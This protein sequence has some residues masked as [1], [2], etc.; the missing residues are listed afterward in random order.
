MGRNRSLRRLRAFSRWEKKAGGGKR[1]VMR[2][3]LRKALEEG[4]DSWAAEHMDM[5]AGLLAETTGEERER[6]LEAIARSDVLL[7]EWDFEE[8]PGEI[9]LSLWEKALDAAKFPR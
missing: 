8:I 1:A 7:A 2:G 4:N 3:V 5:M 6:L 9:A